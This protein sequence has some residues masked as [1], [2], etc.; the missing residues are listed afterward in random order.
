MAPFSYQSELQI[1]QPPD[2]EGRCFVRMARLQGLDRIVDQLVCDDHFHPPLGNLLATADL[3]DERL[4]TLQSAELPLTQYLP[5]ATVIQTDA[6]AAGCEYRLFD[7]IQMGFRYVETQFVH[8]VLREWATE[9][10]TS[11]DANMMSV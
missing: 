9:Q 8:Q 1:G 11:H 3:T 6:P 10:Q 7:R 2:I 5:A 4:A